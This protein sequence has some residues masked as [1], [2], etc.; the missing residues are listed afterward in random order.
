M[1]PVAGKAV[2][3]VSIAV[4][5]LFSTYAWMRVSDDKARIAENEARRSQAMADA[6]KSAELKAAAAEKEA[7][8]KEA[9]AVKKAKENRVKAEAD[10]AKAK[11]DAVIATAEAEKAKADAEKSK[12]DAEKAKADRERAADELSKAEAEKAK[13]DAEKA[14]ANAALEK[15]KTALKAVETA[16]NAKIQIAELETERVKKAADKAEAEAKALELRRMNLE[17][18]ARELAAYKRDLD[19]REEALRPEKTIMDIETTSDEPQ[20]GFGASAKK[21]KVLPENDPYLPK[22]SRELA[23]AKRLEAERREAAVAEVRSNAVSRLER[24]YVESVKADRMTDAE[25]YRKE[26]KRMYP[27]WVY[28]PPEK[29]EQKEEK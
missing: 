13:A 27:G 6:A 2:S 14:A 23:K 17:E 9:A 25:F 7:E 15:E 3:V 19:E 26:L 12:A 24:L 28:I 29:K 16:E 20:E 1:S 22:E 21:A 4:A 11:D 8:I 5:V 10:A 18:I